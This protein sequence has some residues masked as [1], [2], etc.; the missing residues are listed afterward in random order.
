[1]AV[2]FTVVC[3]ELLLVEPWEPLRAG[4]AVG[5]FEAGEDAAFSVFAFGLSAAEDG[6]GGV[7]L[8]VAGGGGGEG[9]VDGGVVE[10]E[11]G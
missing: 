1:M 3:S 6:G 10:E 11:G 2:N 5:F 8:E 4:V 9:A 7:A